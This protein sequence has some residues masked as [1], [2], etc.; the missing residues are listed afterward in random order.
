MA[1]TTLTATLN[2][3]SDRLSVRKGA[4]SYR[5]GDAIPLEV[6]SNLITIE[7]TPSDRRLLTQTYTVDAFREGSVESDREALVALY[8]STGGSGWTD[9]EAWLSDQ[10]LGTWHGVA[11]D[12]AG[13]VVGLDL[14]GNNLRGTLP[15]KLA[16][17][18]ELASLD[19]S[20]NQLRGA[21]PPELRGLSRLTTLDLGANRLSGAIPPGLADLSALESLDLSSNQLRGA[22]PP[23]LAGLTRLTSLVLGGNQLNGA[24]PAVLGDLSSLRELSLRDN[25]LTGPIPAELGALV[26]LDVLYL[27]GNRLSGPI[28]DALG[29]LFPQATRFAGNALT[30]CVPDGLRRLVNVQPFEGLPAHD[31]VA[32]DADDDGDTDDPGDTPGLGLPFCTLRSL[33]LSD[34]TLN[35][36][37]TSSTTTYTGSAEHAVTAT[38]V[39]A[40]LHDFGDAISITTGADTTIYMNGESVPLAVGP[41]VITI[42]VTATD[43]TPTPHRYRVTVT[44]APNTPPVFGEGKAA[45]RGVAENTAAGVNIGGP[46]AATDTDSADRLTYSLDAAGA[47]SFDINALSGQLRTRAALDHETRDRYRVSVSVSDGVDANSDPDGTTDNTIT[48]TVLVSNVNEA[49]EFAPGTASRTIAESRPA[50]VT[51]GAPLQATDEDGDTLTYSMDLFGDADFEIDPASGQVRTRAPLDHRVRAEWELSIIATDP[52]GQTGTVLVIVTVLD[53]DNPG[54]VTV[55]PVQPLVG[56]DL[57]ASLEDPDRL[58]T[59]SLATWKWERSTRRTSGWTTIDGATSEQYRTVEADEDRYLRATASYGEGA[60]KS[61]SAVSDNPVR[62][63]A[64]GNADPEFMPFRSTRTIDENQ[65]AG[66]PIGDPIVATDADDDTL[67]YFLSGTDAASFEINASTGQLRTRAVLDYEAGTNYQFLVVATDGAGGA[68]VGRVTVRVGNAEDAG[69]VRLSSQQPLVAFPLAATLVDPDR[70]RGSVTWVW[71]RS[72]N[73]TSSW[74]PIGGA[75]SASYTPVAG[76]VGGYLRASASYEDRAGP[77]KSAQAVSANAV[78]VAPG[79][80]APVFRDGANTTRNVAKNTPAGRDIGAPVAATDADNDRLSYS[81]GGPDADLFEI[82]ESFGQLR[83]QADLSL[84]EQDEYMVTV[85][86]R[87]GKGNPSTVIDATIE[88]TI[89]TT[90][91]PGGGGGGGGTPSGGAGGGGS[92]GPTPS[93]VDFEWNVTRDIEA[94]A[95]GHDEATGMWS[96]GVTMWLAHN[97]DGAD[98][99]LYAYDLESGERVEE[100]EFELDEANRAP[101]G[102]WSDGTV[103]WIAD[104][105]RDKLFAH[106]LA[107]GERLAAE[108]FALHG[109]NAD[110]R[111]IWSDGETLWVLDGGDDALFAY[112]FESGELLAEYALASANGDPRGLFFDG[113]TFWVSDHGAKRLFAYRLEAGEDGALAL[114]RYRDEEFPNTVLSRASNNSPRGIWSDGDVMYVADASDS[115]VYSYN[116]PDAIDARLASLSLSGVDFGEFDPGR[117][118]YEAVVADGVTETTVEAV[119]LQRGA[120][121]AIDPPDA[122]EDAGGFQVALAGVEAITLTVSSAD[123]SRTKL[124]RVRFAAAAWDPARDPWPHC[125]R[126]AV[127]E[128][129]SLVVF[130]GGGVD[131]LVSC[132]A[133]RDITALYALH[134]G[135]YVPYILGAPD[136]VNRDFSELFAGGLPVMA[137]LVAGSD[138]PP[139]ADPFGDDLDGGVQPPAECLRGAAAPGFS[140]AVYAGGSVEELVACAESRQVTAL[141]ALHEGEFV[142]YILGAPEFVNQPFQELYPDG[143]PPL[144]PLVLKN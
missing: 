81:L 17:L 110:A 131:E 109:D 118:D 26:Q 141:Y 129:F 3:A 105:G 2:D 50:G 62:T 28:P 9:N 21:I 37:F 88:V 134:E 108:D 57:T 22:I 93:D 115:R 45:T 71:A 33:A 102:V 19:L 42:E 24:I 58:P 52:S 125:L 76:D 120:E 35:P 34:V 11:V 117:P 6:G 133:S 116:M 1:T 135:V 63:L 98:D 104:S 66:T 69:A 84:D 27:D 40:T 112:E 44:R 38:R 51:V 119:A 43:G 97:G 39:N 36:E 41:N 55:S 18:T 103:I 16:T 128:G 144:T 122:D 85:S 121:V 54:T 23:D 126:G 15:A 10:D 101:R 142:P 89:S 136:F 61:A 107:T 99:A 74:T 49:P 90:G 67:R 130:A 78:A 14:A 65:P 30:G 140:L 8:N 68:G 79:R 47:E 60:G 46:L 113:V 4:T 12:G 72:P 56:E 132:A 80:N 75:T 96:D 138:G 123:A 59:S 87:D 64:A 53:V 77:G 31:F 13:R 86:V 70:V 83:T 82:D 94:L 5:A 143:L 95:G 48:V 32:V 114:E 100:R 106:D 137:P 20:G 91:A 124:Y 73:G 92:A 111:G 127:S 25:R 29:D 139:S 7:V